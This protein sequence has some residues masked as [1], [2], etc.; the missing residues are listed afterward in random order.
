[1]VAVAAACIGIPSLASAKGPSRAVQISQTPFASNELASHWLKHV[2]GALDYP[3]ECERLLVHLAE[4]YG[5]ALSV[6][7]RGIPEPP[8]FAVRNQVE[9]S[10]CSA[11]P[12]LVL[13]REEP[14]AYGRYRWALFDTSLDD[15]SIEEWQQKARRAD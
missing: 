13:S 12:S 5:N 11:I 8:S 10:V 3:F 2:V 1:M 7:S 4:H 9:R 14:E 6:N 15:Q